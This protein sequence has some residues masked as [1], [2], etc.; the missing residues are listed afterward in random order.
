MAGTRALPTPASLSCP[1]SRGWH[2][3]WVASQ[4]GEVTSLEQDATLDELMESL[5]KSFALHRMGSA[6]NFV[7]YNLFFWSLE[8][9]QAWK[10]MGL[11]KNP[12]LFRWPKHSQ[13]LEYLLVY[14]TPWSWYLELHSVELGMGLEDVIVTFLSPPPV[15]IGAHQCRSSTFLSAPTT[16]ASSSSTSDIDLGLRSSSV[17][18]HS[19]ML[20]LV[21]D[22][23]KNISCITSH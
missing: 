13:E 10:M 9:S 5:H 22:P 2:C 14:G 19:T 20:L 4:N 6:Q 3:P 11:P 12:G 7:P 21:S 18:A 16:R 8:T 23:A 15:N 17:I 1:W